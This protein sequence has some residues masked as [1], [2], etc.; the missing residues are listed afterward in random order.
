MDESRQ[1][2][3]ADFQWH[4]FGDSR[5]QQPFKRMMRKKQRKL[6]ELLVVEVEGYWDQT[7]LCQTTKGGD[8]HYR[9]I[10]FQPCHTEWEGGL[11]W[12]TLPFIL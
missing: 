4:R 2:A 10:T 1:T 9:H 8:D 3:A 5:W 7:C 11:E 12:N 6:I